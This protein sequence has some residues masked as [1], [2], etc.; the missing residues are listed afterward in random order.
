LNGVLSALGHGTIQI[1][2]RVCHLPVSETVAMCREEQLSVSSS[3]VG[4]R[5]SEGT[6]PSLCAG[7]G[8]PSSG[9]ELV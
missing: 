4:L 8:A 7:V 3:T 2:A 9:A 1:L 6:M 5:V